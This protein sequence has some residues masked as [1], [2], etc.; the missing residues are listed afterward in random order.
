ML[1]DP[2]WATIHA[3][4]GHRDEFEAVF[5]DW[6]VDRTR[7]EVFTTCQTEGVMCAPVVTMDEVYHDPQN[8]HR[9]F[10]REVSHPVAGKVTLPGAPFVFSEAPWSVGRPAPR[11][12]EHND[13]VFRE[14]GLG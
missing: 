4:P 3:R 7:L 2:R 9:K 8:V 11:L 5:L 6:L 13:E 1:A 12:G 14:A 10:F